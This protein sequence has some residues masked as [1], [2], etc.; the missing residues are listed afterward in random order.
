MLKEISP[1][2]IVR[3]AIESKQAQQQEAEAMKFRL[4]RERLEAERKTH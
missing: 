3:V 1:P 4:Q 2:E